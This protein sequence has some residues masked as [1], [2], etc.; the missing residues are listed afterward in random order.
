MK[1]RRDVSRGRGMM[2]L[3]HAAELILILLHLQ[4][5]IPF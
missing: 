1:G 4:L 3:R 5:S 2:D